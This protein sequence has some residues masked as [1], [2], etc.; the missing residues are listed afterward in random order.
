MY[1]IKAQFIWIFPL[2]ILFNFAHAEVVP[3]KAKIFPISEDVRTEMMRYSW[4]PGCPV[5]IENLR[6]VKIPYWGFDEHYHLGEL[7]VNEK[8]AN[9]IALIFTQLAHDHFLIRSIKRIE[10]F[11]GDDQASMK[12]DNSSAFNCR[13]I[14][15]QQQKFSLHSYGLAV[16]INTVENPYVKGNIIEPEEGKD[17]LNRNIMRP[18]MISHEMPVYH[19]FIDKGWYWGG[20]F[21]ELK[22]YQHFEYRLE[23]LK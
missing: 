18:G 21:H 14:T 2:M 7:V 12:V 9:D 11:H 4:H 13:A 16:D 17:Y 5:A 15:G 10:A 22:D 8:V 3:Y 19:Y 23:K 6:L 1:R 20:D